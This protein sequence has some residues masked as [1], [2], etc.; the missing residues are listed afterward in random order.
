M[1]AC[2]NGRQTAAIRARI[3][4]AEVRLRNKLAIETLVAHNPD[5]SSLAVQRCC[6][7]CRKQTLKRTH[8]RRSA[9]TQSGKTVR[10]EAGPNA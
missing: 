5:C 1:L 4:L 3:T 6:A 7:H 8:Q 9:R 10:L 2:R